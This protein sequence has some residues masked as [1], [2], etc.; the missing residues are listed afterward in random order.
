MSDPIKRASESGWIA[1]HRSRYLADGAAGHLWDST[2]AGGPGPLPTLLLTTRGR[3]SGQ[4]SVMPLLYGAVAGG[5]AIIA[6]K[7]GAPQ[8][9]G[10]FHNLRAQ[11]TVTVQVANEVFSARPRIAEGAERASI[12]R[13]MVAMY[14]PFADYQAKTA[15]E[16]PVVVLE[17][18]A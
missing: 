9:P 2:F 4:D 17:R 1:E 15:R 12:W 16:I 6:S 8:H 11:D 10:W 18:D 14:P 5:Y 7:G 3:K 13:Q